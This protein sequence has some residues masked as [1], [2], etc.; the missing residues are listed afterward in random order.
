LCRRLKVGTVI[1]THW[2]VF[3]P[4]DLGLSL[5][6]TAA[7]TWLFAIGSTAVFDVFRELAAVFSTGASGTSANRTALLKPWPHL[8]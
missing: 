1:E 8:R 7:S 4:A 6:A 2:I 5:F 3:D